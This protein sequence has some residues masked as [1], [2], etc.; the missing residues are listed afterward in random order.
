M[1]KY[2]EISFKQILL[3]I[4]LCHYY[5]FPISKPLSKP[6]SNVNEEYYLL[7]RIDNQLYDIG[8]CCF[9]NQKRDYLLLVSTPLGTPIS[10]LVI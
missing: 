5:Q 10:K 6:L 7:P 9:L 8:L 4:F 3:E 1:T 2:K